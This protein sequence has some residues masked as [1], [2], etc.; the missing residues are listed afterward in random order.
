MPPVLYLLGR[1]PDRK[2]PSVAIVGAR[3][4]S[5]YGNEIARRFAGA[6]AS[7]GVQIISGMA[8]G[9][10]GMAHK[11]ALEADGYLLSG[12]AQETV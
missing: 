12:R 3:R 6:L 4:S 2:R 10:D 8:W 11:G 7:A 9:I 5:S 1:L